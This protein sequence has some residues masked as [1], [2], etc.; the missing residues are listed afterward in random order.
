MMQHHKWLSMSVS[1]LLSACASAPQQQLASKPAEQAPIAAAVNGQGQWPNAQWWKRY[2]DPMLD[3][4]I[5]WAI[6]SGPTVAIAETRVAQAQHYIEVVAGQQGVQVAGYASASRQRLSDHG[7]IPPKFL[8]FNWYNQMDLG[9]RANYSFDWWHKQREILAATL[10]EAQ[11]AHAERT[12]VAQQLS[13]A[14]A[15]AYFGWQADQAQLALVIQQQD[16]L[17]KRKQITQARIEAQLEPKDG[18]H[19][20]EIEIAAMNVARTSI[21]TSASLRRVLIASLLGANPDELPAFTSRTLPTLPLQLPNQVS[22]DLLARR[23]DIEV[24]RLQIEAAQHRLNVASAEFMPDISINALVGL[25]S[26]EVENLFKAGSATPGFGLALHLPMFDTKRLNAQFGIRATQVEQAVVLYNT[27]LINAAREVSTQA[28]IKQQ[29]AQSQTER[30]SQITSA[31]Q[32]VT[33]AQKRKEYGV[34]DARPYLQA[35]QNLYQQQVALTEVR[36]QA[37]EADLAL[38]AALGGG[39]QR[40]DVLR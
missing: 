26:I 10:N 20:L 14:V 29:L 6:E 25:S 38:I 8:G 28:L 22:I 4:L 21:E 9:V 36:A 33:V 19:A 34:A 5:E 2:A 24:S 30:Q 11:I 15:T 7:M 32:L 23:A 27:T 40:E 35:L 16:V 31:E 39:Y 37:V 12:L 17:A 1:L 13:T 18:L 3:Q